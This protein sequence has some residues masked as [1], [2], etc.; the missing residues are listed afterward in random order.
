MVSTIG[1][2]YG[3]L[4]S[5]AAGISNNV[6]TVLNKKVVNDLPHQEEK[7]FRRLFKNPL[8]LFGWI[9]QIVVGSVFFIMAQIYIGPALIPGLEA[10]GLIFL[11]IG[12]VRIVHEKLNWSEWLGIVL[13]IGAIAMLG[14]S[15]L[16]IQIAVNYTRPLFFLRILIFSGVGFGSALA[17]FS[18]R[19]GHKNRAIFYAV[20]SGFL[21]AMSNFWISP[22][23]GVIEK[24]FLGTA[25][26]LETIIFIVACVILILCNFFTIT[27]LQMAFQTGQA[28]NLVPIQQVPIQIAPIFVYFYIFWGLAAK[29]PLSHDLLMI[30]SI[31]LIIA[32]TFLLGRRQAQLEK[33]K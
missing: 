16:S 2:A 23:I 30:I 15:S 28:S 6:G 24:V 31:G 10:I 33:I 22:L 7:F 27:T 32:S 3:V 11:A 18:T 29:P 8:W 19:K 26:P 9:L 4:L 25:L 13:L 14:F 20:G 21:V 12:A 17:C 1:Y 5:L